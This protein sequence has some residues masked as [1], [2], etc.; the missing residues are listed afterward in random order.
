MPAI[1][2]SHGAPDLLVT[3]VPARTFLQ[4]LLDA[5][6]A[7]PR[8]ILV[9]S[10][11][12]ETGAPRVD[13][14]D[15]PDTIHDFSGFAPALYRLHHAAPGAPELAAEVVSRLQAAGFSSTAPARRGLDHGA[16]VPL[17]LMDPD[18]TIPALQLSIQT[19][20]GPRHHLALGQALAPFREE[21]VL[22]LASGSLTH[23]LSE[24][25]PRRHDVNAPQPAWVTGFADWMDARLAAGDVD[26]LVDYRAQA[27]FAAKNHPTEEHLLPLFVALGAAGD[28]PAAR[29]LHASATFGILRMDS[30]AFGAAA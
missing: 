15:R 9:V 30:Y 18:A 26:A 4:G 1:F 20:L 10:A 21:G 28:A 25:G 6:P 5:L 14:S 12:W 16:W 2:V 23:D 13:A 22:I 27:P 17:A 29:H 24:F 19:A 8:A 3:D 7:R 11:H